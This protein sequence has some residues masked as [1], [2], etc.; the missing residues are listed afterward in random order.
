MARFTDEF[1]ELE[2]VFERTPSYLSPDVHE[3]EYE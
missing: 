3:T 2:R 1:T